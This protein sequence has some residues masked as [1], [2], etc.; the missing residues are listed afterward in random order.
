MSCGALHSPGAGRSG[1][2]G[3][4]T[5]TSYEGRGSTDDGS[6]DRNV[7]RKELND[8]VKG[9]AKTG[10]R[11][12]TQTQFTIQELFTSRGSTEREEDKSASFLTLSGGT[13]NEL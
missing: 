3:Q 11:E 1:Q 8:A 4:G 6:D 9:A 10:Q 2:A 13:Q 5:E 7:T 12:G